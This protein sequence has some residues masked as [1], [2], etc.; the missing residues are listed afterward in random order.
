M[1]YLRFFPNYKYSHPHHNHADDWA[2][3]L[4]YLTNKGECGWQGKMG[5]L[6]YYHKLRELNHPCKMLAIAD[7]WLRKELEEMRSHKRTEKALGE[8]AH[9]ET[10]DKQ[11]GGYASGRFFNAETGDVY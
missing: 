9:A 7:Q 5:D 4:F 8:L 6:E 10:Y 1:M 3:H 2:S 11:Q